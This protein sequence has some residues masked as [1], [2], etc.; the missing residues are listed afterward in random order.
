MVHAL[1]R[2]E[3]FIGDAGQRHLIDIYSLAGD[4]MQEEVDRPLENIQSHLI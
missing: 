3:V 2:T 4:E 1:E